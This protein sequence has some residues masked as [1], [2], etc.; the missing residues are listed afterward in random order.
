MSTQQTRKVSPF[1]LA[2]RAGGITVEF[3]AED[4]ME[5]RPDWSHA[6]ASAFLE[7]HTQIVVDA[8]LKAAVSA[9]IDAMT[10]GGSDVH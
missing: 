2:K 6:E 10:L 5:M 1:A 3:T 9:L 4:V 7:S 8:M